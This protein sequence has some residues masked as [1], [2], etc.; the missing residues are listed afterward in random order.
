MEAVG[1][2]TGGVAHDFNNILMVIMANID[3]LAGDTR[4]PPDLSKRTRR[5]ANATQRAS[6]LT[7]QL[8]AFGAARRCVRNGPT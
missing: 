7:R 2:L 6:D 4:L 3:E 1:R 8:L 5:I